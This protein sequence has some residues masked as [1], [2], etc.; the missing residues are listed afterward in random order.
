MNPS[1][2]ADQS[3]SC[4]ANPNLIR[5]FIAL[6]IPEAVKDEIERVQVELRNVLPQKSVRWTK[7]DQL[8]LTLK[9]LGN[10]EPSRLRELTESLREAC[11]GFPALKLRAERIGC[12]PSL[13]FPRVVWIWVHDDTEQLRGLQQ[14]VE[15]AIEKFAEGKEEKAFTGHVTIARINA[16]KRPKAEALAKTAHAL[17]SRHFGDWTANEVRLMRSELAQSGAVHSALAAFPLT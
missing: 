6:P 12:F 14:R 16:I 10:V 2:D 3:D 9:F 8:H 13:R 1:K 4:P 11:A 7:R 17:T 5:A 15:S